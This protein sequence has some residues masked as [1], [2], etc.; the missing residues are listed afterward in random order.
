V[1]SEVGLDFLDRDLGLVIAKARSID[2]FGQALVLGH[3]VDRDATGA[4]DGG[5]F[6]IPSLILGIHALTLVGGG[7][8]MQGLKCLGRGAAAPR[9]GRAPPC[10]LEAPDTLAR[11]SASPGA[12]EDQGG[13]VHRTRRTITGLVLG[14]AVL[15]VLVVAIVARGPGPEA[16]DRR[17]ALIAAV[18][19]AALGD[20]LDLRSVLRDDWERVGFL[21][22]YYRNESASRVLGF[23]FDY[24][25]ASPWQNAEGGT[26][27]V[28]AK[29]DAAVAWFAV[30]SEQIGFVC[31]DGEAVAAIE[32]KFEVV[33]I[34]GTYRDLL[35][36]PRPS[37]C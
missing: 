3:G 18:S 1:S 11:P 15:L 12:S 20:Q 31:L 24:E 37:R 29:N 27:V 32:A 21:G 35:P 26:V 22:P 2:Q 30:P 6:R 7:P 23:G 16:T 9:S 25:A 19:N 36:I 5:C 4:G 8:E 13:C 34:E 14:V 28:L 17:D 10:G 33:E